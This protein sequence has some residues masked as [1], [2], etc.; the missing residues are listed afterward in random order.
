LYR[1]LA[2]V[3][4]AGLGAFAYAR[5]HHS[6][7]LSSYRKHLRNDAR[8][9]RDGAVRVTAVGT[10]MLLVDDGQTQILIDPYFSSVSLMDA[11]LNRAVSTD[12][13]GVEAALDR[14]G[15]DRV[16]AILVSHSH[17]DHALD[18][19]Y[20]AK[21]T[22]ALVVGSASALNIARGGGVS[23]EKLRL[24]EPGEAFGVGD[25][26]VRPLASRHSPHVFGGEGATID[27]PLRQPASIRAYKEGGTFDFLVSRKGHTMLFKNS[28]NWLPGA[29]DAI[30]ADALFLGVG[31][32]GNE[33]EVFTEKYFDA[34]IDVVHPRIV[35]ATH[36]NDFFSPVVPPLPLERVVLGH[37]PLAFDRLIAR[38]SRAGAQ[39]VILDAFS[40]VVLFDST[41]TSSEGERGT[42]Q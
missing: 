8:A 29:L 31:G 27:A 41:I 3:F 40:D 19:G 20:V 42:N 34:T 6:G 17:F 33:D 10:T 21:R 13:R 14:L 9:L 25:F 39:T 35:V 30:R 12:A 28:A 22:G 2:L 4:A 26:I 38:A 16:K 5:L 11:A 23:E 7:N 15:A 36:W 37:T 1:S 32:L 18:L 24:V